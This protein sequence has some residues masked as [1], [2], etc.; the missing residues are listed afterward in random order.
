MRRRYAAMLKV[1]GAKEYIERHWLEK[2][3]VQVIAKAF[4]ISY[5][6]LAPL[7]KQREGVT[8]G[9]YY[10]KVKVDHIK[11]A[12]ADPSLSVAEAFACCGANNQSEAGK[13]FKRLTGMSPSEY[14][15]SLES[16]QPADVGSR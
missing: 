8:M 3:D 16:N 1:A 14:R 4:G 9:Q 15:K 5:S 6:S 12:L 10:I 7:F 11:E 2:L 13:A